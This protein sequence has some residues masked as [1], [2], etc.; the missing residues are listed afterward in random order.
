MSQ[1]LAQITDDIIFKRE[2][3]LAHASTDYKF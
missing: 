2:R 1:V 3:K